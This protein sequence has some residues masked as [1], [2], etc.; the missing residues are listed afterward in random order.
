MLTFTTAGESHGCGIVTVIEGLPAGLAVDL[1]EVNRELAR[2]CR[3]FGRGA[4]MAIE[5]DTAEVLGGLRFGRTIGA[6]LCILVRNRDWRK[7]EKPGD[8]LTVPRPGHADLP[9]SLK[10]QRSDLR[11]ILERASARETVGRVAAG[12]VCKQLLWNLDIFIGSFVTAIGSARLETGI[13]YGSPFALQAMHCRAERS[14]V[15][16]VDPRLE[17]RMVRAIREAMARK[18]TLGGVFT[19]FAVNPPVGLGSHAQW[20]DRLTARIGMHLLSIPAVRSVEFGLGAAAAA[21]PGSRVHDPITV[22]RGRLCRSGNNAGG[23]EGG[24]SNGESIVVSCAMKPIPTLGEPLQSVDLRTGR[25]AAAPVI[26]SDV[27][28]VPA[29]AVIGEAMLAVALA[30]EVRRVFGGD[31]LTEMVRAVRTRQK[32]QHRG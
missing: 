21:L 7:D 23:V 26:R 29:C 31:S 25:P 30:G 9:G 16:A 22:H 1:N 18:D 6:P 14:P 28:A 4:R 27:T 13:P 19:V 2:R 24:I 3:G 8:A 32:R 12:A 11:D 10:Y 15:R 5:Q 17:R 20:R